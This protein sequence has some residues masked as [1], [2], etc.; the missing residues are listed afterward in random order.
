MEKNFFQPVTF[1]GGILLFIIK[2]N[3]EI[4]ANCAANAGVD[5]TFC[6]S[7]VT[8]AIRASGDI[9]AFSPAWIL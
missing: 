2:G 3:A 8:Q 7:S 5:V 4:I 6:S 1:I 9:C